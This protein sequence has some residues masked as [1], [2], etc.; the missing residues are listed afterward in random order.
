MVP[1]KTE[2]RKLT[3]MLQLNHPNDNAENMALGVEYEYNKVFF[4]RAGYKINVKNQE[5]PS[6][7][8]GLIS[9]IGRNP[10]HIDYAVSSDNALSLNH[11]IGI[12]LYLNQEN[13]DEK[14]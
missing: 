2:L 14:K 12:A 4:M 8:L 10:L 3:V 13:R 1:I 11:T 9:R 5:I 6:V 7:G